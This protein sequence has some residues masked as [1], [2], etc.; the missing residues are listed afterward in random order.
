MKQLI[1]LVSLLFALASCA[2]LPQ[3]LPPANPVCP[4]PIMDSSLLCAATLVLTWFLL[5]RY[6]QN[7]WSQSLISGISGYSILGPSCPNASNYCPNGICI[8]ALPQPPYP[9]LI[10]SHQCGWCVGIIKRT[11]IRDNFSIIYFWPIWMQLAATA[12]F[13]NKIFK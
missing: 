9:L 3:P 6:H 13:F 12:I 8:I 7:V 1:I 4:P 10:G 5:G 11:P 2:G